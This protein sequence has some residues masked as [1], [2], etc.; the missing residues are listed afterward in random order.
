MGGPVNPQEY[1]L[2]D[3]FCRRSFPEQADGQVVDPTE[4]VIEKSGQGLAI[5]LADFFQDRRGQR[6]AW[7]GS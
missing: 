6:G 3:V 1:F 5:P 2:G 4:I 7:A